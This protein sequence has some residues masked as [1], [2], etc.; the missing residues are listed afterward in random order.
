MDEQKME[1]PEDLE[2]EQNLTLTWKKN[3]KDRVECAL[4]LF[5]DAF[6]EETSTKTMVANTMSSS[7]KEKKSVVKSRVG[8]GSHRKIH[9]SSELSIRYLCDNDGAHPEKRIIS[10]KKD[11]VSS[12]SSSSSSLNYLS[13]NKKDVHPRNENGICSES[14]LSICLESISSPEMSQNQM[15]QEL[16][17][18]NMETCGPLKLDFDKSTT[19][20]YL[21]KV[22]HSKE[23]VPKEHVTKYDKLV[24]EILEDPN[25]V[26]GR[27]AIVGFLTSL[28]KDPYVK[29]TFYYGNITEYSTQTKSWTVTIYEPLKVY[30]NAH[31]VALAMARMFRGSK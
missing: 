9:F 29:Q 22:S 8:K 11:D 3:E 2:K 17:E 7:K 10:M 31:E 14:I 15:Q 4:S 20:A 1:C 30:L 26:I 18:S 28:D 13:G 5:S 27:G 24:L 21:R 25:Q 6:E 23:A 16:S 19:A 12:S